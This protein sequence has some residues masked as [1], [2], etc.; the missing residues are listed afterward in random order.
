MVDCEEIKTK[1]EEILEEEKSKKDR[2]IRIKFIREHELK[3]N[4]R[5]LGKCIGVTGQFV[6]VV[7]DGK[8]NFNYKNIKR[9]SD[10]TGHTT[11][12]ILFG[13]S[14]EPLEIARKCVTKFTYEEMCKAFEIMNEVS[15]LIRK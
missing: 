10:L 14:E 11:D 8:A 4:K 6:G 12:Y 5:E 7:E 2:G 9:I 13:L 15:R 1:E 3:M